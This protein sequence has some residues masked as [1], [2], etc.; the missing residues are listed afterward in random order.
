MFVQQAKR[1]GVGAVEFDLEWTLD[2]VAVL[3][4]DDTVERT[5]DGSGTIRLMTYE[6]TQQLDASAKHS[7]RWGVK[8]TFSFSQAVA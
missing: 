5:T 8:E 1:N 3:L 2:G 4:H 7:K 6:S